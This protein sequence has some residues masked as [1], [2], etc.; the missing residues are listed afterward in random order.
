LTCKRS[1][2]RV[3]CRPPTRGLI[4]AIEGEYAAAVAREYATI[5]A[6]ALNATAQKAA[7]RAQEVGQR[8]R[9]L[10]EQAPPTRDGEQR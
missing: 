9:R 2:V 5:R 7:Q 8:L 6:A 4:P 1:L 10:E 3:Q